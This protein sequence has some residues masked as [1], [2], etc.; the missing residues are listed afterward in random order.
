MCSSTSLESENLEKKQPF[1]TSLWCR[2]EEKVLTSTKYK[3][4]VQILEKVSTSTST[5]STC[6]CN[7]IDK[8][9]YKYLT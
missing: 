3:V 2:V 8:Y 4:Q 9:K 7:Q 6:T 1:L 5:Q